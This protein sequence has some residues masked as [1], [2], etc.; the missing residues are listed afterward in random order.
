MKIKKICVQCGGTY[1]VYPYREH[2]TYFC[3]PEC[4][5]QSRRKRKIKICPV[6]YKEFEVKESAQRQG[7]CGNKCMG[8]YSSK[9]V[10]KK[11]AICEKE[12]FPQFSIRNKSKYCSKKCFGISEKQRERKRNGENKTC[13]IC[14]KQFYCNPAYVNRRICCSNPCKHK[15]K[16]LHNWKKDEHLFNYYAGRFK[17]VLLGKGKKP[18]ILKD[19]KLTDLDKK[20]IE[21]KVLL[22]KIR[23]ENAKKQET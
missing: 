22:F 20:V 23:R 7:Y 5:F 18:I 4:S 3:S 9:R 10:G 8:I 19:F 6:C 16:S 12:Y 13:Q 11:C 14:G 21:A 1:W 15:Y 2:T 17:T